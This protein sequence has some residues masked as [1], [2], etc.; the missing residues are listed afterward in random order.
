MVNPI[1]LDRLPPCSL[2]AEVGVLGCIML[3]PDD[4]MP[5]AIDRIKD[6]AA[7]YDL[8]H[9]TIYEAMLAM[10][11]AKQPID[12]ITLQQRLK[13]Q[14]QLD[15]VGGL[16]FISALPDSVPSAANIEYYLDILHE[17]HV[18]RKMIAA[19][20]DIVSRAYEHEGE[21]DGLLSKLERNVLELSTDTIVAPFKIRESV[22][23][24]ISTIEALHQ[25]Q[26]TLSGLSTGFVDLNKM[27]NGLHPGE[28]IIIAARPSMGK[29]SL[30]MNIAESVAVDQKEPVGIFSLEMNADSL[31]LRMLCSRARVNLRSVQDGFL[32]ERDFPKL[33]NAA[34]KIANAG[35]HIDDSATLTLS[36][37]RARARRLHQVH[38]IKLLIIDYL[39]LLKLGA[40]CDSRQQEVAQICHGIKA[41]AKELQVPVIVLSQL[42][43]EMEKGGKGGRARRPRMSDLRES[44]DIEQD[45]DLVGLLFK[46]NEKTEDDYEPGGNL[47]AL[48][49]G[50][51]I[52]KQRSGP[53]G[54]VHLTFLKAYTRFESAAK[55]AQDDLPGN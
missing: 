11:D 6:T 26:G 43:R 31:V 21:V 13:D 45:A 53:T 1:A 7:F 33:A 22:Q 2:E 20:T 49:V 38:A 25:R 44:G 35:I 9:R 15:S 36:Q 19:C 54:V 4:V 3:S 18:L 37:L 14:Q 5:D 47:E 34:G 27:T 23:R 24:G 55:I 46:E 48:P 28:M 32:S 41:L 50:L 30:A 17:K 51:D 29:T 42:N 16:A 40:R 10:Y 8:R 12:T 52:A 39:Q